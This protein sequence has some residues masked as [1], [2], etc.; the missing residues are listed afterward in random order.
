MLRE[1]FLSQRLE[2]RKD[3]RLAGIS[4]IKMMVASIYDIA[5]VT[6]NRASWNFPNL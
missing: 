4:R 5:Y 6:K 3:E 2:L 1:S